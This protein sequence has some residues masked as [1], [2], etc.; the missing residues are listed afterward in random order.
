MYEQP[1]PHTVISFPFP[2][3]VIKVITCK[4]YQNCYSDL[5]SK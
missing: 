5:C 3:T 1:F 2:H 4:Q